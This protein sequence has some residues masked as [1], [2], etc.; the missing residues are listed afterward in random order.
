MSPPPVFAPCNDDRLPAEQ[1][2]GNA[3]KQ[4]RPVELAPT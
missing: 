3:V 4:V 2:I 1:L